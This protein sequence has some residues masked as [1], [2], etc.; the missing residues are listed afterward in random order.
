MVTGSEQSIRE[1]LRQPVIRVIDAHITVL[2]CDGCHPH[3]DLRS[4]PR[5]ELIPHP[6]SDALCVVVCCTYDAATRLVTANAIGVRLWDGGQSKLWRQSL[7]LSL[8]EQL[9]CER[10]ALENL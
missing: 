7:T 6:G 3:A 2:E 5:T 8:T 1:V 9:Q 4:F 10:R